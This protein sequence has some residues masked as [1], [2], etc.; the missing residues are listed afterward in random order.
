VRRQ[1]GPPEV[2]ASE[3]GLVITG[4]V[5]GVEHV[6]VDV[7]LDLEAVRIGVVAEQLRAEHVYDRCPTT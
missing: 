4:G 6:A 7:V 5:Q 1:H 2:Q 3:A